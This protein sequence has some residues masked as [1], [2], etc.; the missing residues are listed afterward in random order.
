MATQVGKQKYDKGKYSKTDGTDQTVGVNNSLVRSANVNSN[1]NSTVSAASLTKSGS[2]DEFKFN[3]AMEQRILAA[4]DR[5]S[6]RQQARARK[7]SG[8]DD[9]KSQ[10]TP[11]AEPGSKLYEK[12]LKLENKLNKKFVVPTGEEPTLKQSA[13][14]QNIDKK[15][16][17]IA[18]SIDQGTLT[19]KQAKYAMRKGEGMTPDK[20]GASGVG[21]KEDYD[22]LLKSRAYKKQ[23]AKEEGVSVRKI[24]KLGY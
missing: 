7:L 23:R 8:G 2:S 3:P 20:A 14:Q 10:F 16:S 21:Y 17:E 15:L 24:K 6:M 19:V 4:K 1:E 13:R 18:K 5:Q 11:G 9:V 12:N 22:K